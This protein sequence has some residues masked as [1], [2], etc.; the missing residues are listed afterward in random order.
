MRFKDQVV[1]ITG[2]S[3]GIGEG[4]AYAFSREGARLILSARRAD[5]LERVKAAC[6]GPG[7]ILLLPFDMVDDAGRQAAVARALAH[8]GHVDML[9]NNAGISQRSLGKDTALAVDRQIMELDYFAVIAL[10]KLVLPSMIARKRGHLVATS[11][12]A[13]KFGVWHRT[14]YCAAKHALHGFF[15]ALRVELHRDNIDVSL[16]VIAG[17]QTDVSLHALTG[18]GTPFGRMDPTQSEGISVA[19]CARIVVDGL[20]RKDHEINVVSGR[21]RLALW[22]ARYWPRRLYRV[23]TRTRAGAAPPRRA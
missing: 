21:G 23:M 11:S 1:W 4:L 8:F 20:A 3:A 18:D 10:T 13:G 15:D 12:V 16:L 19:D 22:L 14:A 9:I 6:R 5:A 7:E 17:V 2:A